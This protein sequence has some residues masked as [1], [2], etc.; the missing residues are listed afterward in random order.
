M[1]QVEY[2]KRV[3]NTALTETTLSVPSGKDYD[4]EMRSITE[5]GAFSKPFAVS[6]WPFAFCLP[7]LAARWLPSPA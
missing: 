2:G 6:R 4:Y 1:L 3:T 5:S 7:R